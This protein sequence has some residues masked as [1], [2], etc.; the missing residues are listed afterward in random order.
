[1]S[2]IKE[3]TLKEWYEEAEKLYGKSQENWKFK[4]PRCGHVASIKDFIEAGSDIDSAAQNCIGRI[5]KGVGC[6]WAAYGL[7]GTLDKG[8]IVI[9]EDG[10]RVNVFDFAK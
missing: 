8:R 2:N 4:C 3:Q 9:T 10:T 5:K 6:D 1:M 7:F